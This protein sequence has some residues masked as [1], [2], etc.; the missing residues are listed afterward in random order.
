[1]LKTEAYMKQSPVLLPHSRVV[2][3]LIVELSAALGEG[4]KKFR[5]I[6][7]KIEQLCSTD[8]MKEHAET[9]FRKTRAKRLFISKFSSAEIS[10]KKEFG[11]TCNGSL[12]S[13]QQQSLTLRLP[14]MPF[15]DVTWTEVCYIAFRKPGNSLLVVIVIVGAI[16]RSFVPGIFA[17]ILL[18]SSII[19]LFG[20][21]WVMPAFR[22]TYYSAVASIPSDRCGLSYTSSRILI[23]PWKM[24]PGSPVALKNTI[25]N[26]PGR[27]LLK[28]ISVSAGFL[29]LLFSEMVP[30]QYFGLLIL[31]SMVASGISALTFL[32][33]I[34]ILSYRRRSIASSREQSR[35]WCRL[36]KLPNICVFIYY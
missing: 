11:N 7:D 32:P 25:G 8:S 22:W 24:G 15:I 20:L 27:P 19:I 26:Q 23:M 4:R 12:M 9:G 18:I 2:A 34:L 17:A 35:E 6:S 10:A 5:M 3:D 33:A 1:M 30:L 36:N 14:G 21:W 28:C 31:L 16:L 29:V 13:I